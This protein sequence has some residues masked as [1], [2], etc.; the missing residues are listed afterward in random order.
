MNNKSDKFN[1][2]KLWKDYSLGIILGALFILSWVGQFVSQL[3]EFSNEQASL[4]EPFNFIEFIPAFLSS[5]FEN[6][7]SEFL[8]LL[9]MVV[10]TTYFVFKGSHES[11]DNDEKI[12]NLL[13]EINKKLD[14]LTDKS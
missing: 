4:G 11:K 1:L 10:F 14:V 6:W 5:T 12:E 7:Q 9:S 13:N 2:G 3:I 8:Q